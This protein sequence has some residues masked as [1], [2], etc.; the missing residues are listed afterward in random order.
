[1]VHKPLLYRFFIDFIIVSYK[2]ILRFTAVNDW[3]YD[4]QLFSLLWFTKGAPLAV[5]Y[6]SDGNSLPRKIIKNVAEFY[7]NFAKFG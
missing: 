5:Q 3:N 6:S 2:N 7:A 1:M 4:D